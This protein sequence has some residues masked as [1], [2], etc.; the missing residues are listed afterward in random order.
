MVDFLRLITAANL[1]AF[2]W[3]QNFFHSFFTQEHHAETAWRQDFAELNDLSY[4]CVFLRH[5]K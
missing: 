1:D 4:E 5:R 2:A 3:R